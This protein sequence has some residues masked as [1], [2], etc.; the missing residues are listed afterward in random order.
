VA[1]SFNPSFQLE[2]RFDLVAG[3]QRIAVEGYPRRL[4]IDVPDR[5]SL[6][7]AAAR[8]PVTA[9]ID[10]AF[11]SYSQLGG[12]KSTLLPKVGEVPRED[13]EVRD[14]WGVHV[15]VDWMLGGIPAKTRLLAGLFT[16]PSHAFRYKGEISAPSGRAL[17]FAFN[18]R[19]ESTTI[20]WS[21][22]IGRSFGSVADPKL[23][24]AFAW[25]MA[26]AQMNEAVISLVLPR[27]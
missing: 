9:A 26:A 1:Y 22:G 7:L 8:G 18:G 19:P 25:R 4:E 27:W 12:S 24:V 11:E 17:D 2:E 21:V 5:L 14:V 13:F 15:G 6:G 23:R 10:V 16:S 3:G 20:G